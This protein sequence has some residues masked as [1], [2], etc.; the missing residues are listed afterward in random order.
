MS[1]GKR[2]L[3]SGVLPRSKSKIET[4][5]SAT[6]EGKVHVQ[7]FV[8]LVV[9]VVVIVVHGDGVARGA[10]CRGGNDALLLVLLL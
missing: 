4:I 6:G 7:C 8:I 10:D 9:V 5:M 1:K 3:E 2:K